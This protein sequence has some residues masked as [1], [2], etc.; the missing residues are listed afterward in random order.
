[1]IQITSSDRDTL[2]FSTRETPDATRY[3]K[4]A[5]IVSFDG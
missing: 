5:R 2:P 3:E 1:M 4:Q